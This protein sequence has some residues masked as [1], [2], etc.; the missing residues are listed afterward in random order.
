[1]PFQ[2]NLKKS[3]SALSG[4]PNL[5]CLMICKPKSNAYLPS[6]NRQGN[7]DLQRRFEQL[8]A[9]HSGR[10]YNFVLK[11]S[12]GNATLAQ[13][14]TQITFQ[15][16]WE[17][18]DTLRIEHSMQSYLFAIARNTLININE[19]ET[20]EY[21]YLNYILRTCNDNDNSTEENLN[22]TF[23]LGYLNTLID[24][25]PPV[26]QRVFRMSRLEYKSHKEIAEELSISVNTIET[27]IALALRFLRRELARRY[28][29]II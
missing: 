19:R 15:R 12:H 21:V 24:E 10:I 8:Y 26:R 6:M 7:K 9:E 18:L 2:N 27:H 20:L 28:G 3:N 14:V 29:I 22:K 13:D 4:K 1:M 11:M 17:N 25:M 16:L 23:L 5:N